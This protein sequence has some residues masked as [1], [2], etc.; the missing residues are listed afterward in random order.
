MSCPPDAQTDGQ[1]E[2]GKICYPI[3]FWSDSKPFDWRLY[4]AGSSRS[5]A[6]GARSDRQAH[7]RTDRKLGSWRSS[8]SPKAALELAV[9]VISHWYTSMRWQ[10]GWPQVFPISCPCETVLSHIWMNFRNWV[11]WSNA[12]TAHSV[13]FVQYNLLAICVP[14]KHDISI[15][16]MFF[17]LPKILLRP[18]VICY[19]LKSLYLQLISVTFIV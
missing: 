15:F 12:K 3:G 14:C 19:F 10:K 6:L 17:A 4:F 16:V 1:D 11:F 9:E 18:S 7:D 13:F 8:R 2:G 5:Q